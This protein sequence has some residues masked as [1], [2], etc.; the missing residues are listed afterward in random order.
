[1]RTKLTLLEECLFRYNL[2]CVRLQTLSLVFS[3]PVFHIICTFVVD[4]DILTLYKTIVRS[5]LEY[6]TV[7]WPSYHLKDILEIE[8][9]QRIATRMAWNLHHLPYQARLRVLGPHHI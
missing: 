1:M 6:G 8:N 9:I 2:V 5:N 4:V 3:S 7:I